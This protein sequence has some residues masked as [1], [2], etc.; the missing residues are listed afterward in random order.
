MCTLDESELLVIV[1]MQ[2][3]ALEDSREAYNAQIPKRAELVDEQKEAKIGLA[4]A[5]KEAKRA[6]EALAEGERTL[7]VKKRTLVEL[8]GRMANSEEVRTLLCT[9]Q[10]M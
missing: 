7:D 3:K 2:K 4:A 9:H 5:K 1:R 10:R 6:T 8:E